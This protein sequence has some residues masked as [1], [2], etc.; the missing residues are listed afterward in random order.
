MLVELVYVE[1]ASERTVRMLCAFQSCFV[2]RI[3]VVMGHDHIRLQIVGY[4]VRTVEMLAQS[5]ELGVHV[6]H[7]LAK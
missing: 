2:V 6:R 7:V 5:E 4:A 1:S 3:L